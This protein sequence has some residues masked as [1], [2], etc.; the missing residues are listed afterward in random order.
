[1]HVLNS[2]NIFI[3]QPKQFVAAVVVVIVIVAI[4]VV[5][6]FIQIALEHSTRKKTT[7]I[8]IAISTEKKANSKRHKK[9]CVCLKRARRRDCL[10][11]SLVLRLRRRQL[12]L[13]LLRCCVSVTP[14]REWENGR[15]GDSASERE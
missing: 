13:L 7:F 1:M 8:Q 12:L 6:E 3:Y 14:K 5:V 15:V 4:V 9:L 2:I 11:K 10:N